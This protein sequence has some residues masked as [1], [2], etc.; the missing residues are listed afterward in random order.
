MNVSIIGE[1]Q[2]AQCVLRRIQVLLGGAFQQLLR[3]GCVRY[4]QPTVAV[5][6][7]HEVLRVRITLVGNL[8]QFLGDLVPFL[9]RCAF[10]GNNF[11][12]LPAVVGHR[13]V[14]YLLVLL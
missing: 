10:V 6:Q 13:A 7:S 4:Q 14:I 5:Q 11:S 1:I 9:Q 8:L 3:F 2:L 12:Q